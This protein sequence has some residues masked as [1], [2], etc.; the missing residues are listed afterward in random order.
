MPDIQSPPRLPLAE[1]LS[2]RDATTNFDTKLVNSLI[3]QTREGT[4]RAIKRNG[5]ALAYQGTVGTGQGITNYRNNLYAISGD[6][7]NSFTAGGSTAVVQEITPGATFSQRTGAMGAGLGGNLYIMGGFDGTNYLNDVWTSTNGVSWSQVTSSAP[8][9]KRSEGK[10]IVFNGILYIMGGF[11]GTSALG[12]VWSTPDGM[13]WTR[14]SAG[15]WPGR[16]RF[17]LT[18]YNNLMWVAGGAAG[19]ALVPP[20]VDPDLKYSDVYSSPDGIT[21]TRTVAQAPWVARNDFAFYTDST[22]NRLHVTGGALIDAYNNAVGDSWSTTDGI[23]W[24]RDSSNPFGVAAAPLWPVGAGQSAG[25]EE[26]IPA[27]V[28]AT[29]GGGTGQALFGFTDFDDDDGL[30]GDDITLGGYVMVSASNP[31]SGFTSAPTLT[32]GNNAGLTPIVYE[33]L[34]GAANNGQKSTKAAQVGNTTYIMEFSTNNGTFDAVLWS[35]VDGLTFTNVGLPGSGIWVSRNMTYFSTSGALWV[36]AGTDA[37]PNLYNDVWEITFS[38]SAVALNPNVANGFY[39]FNQTSLGIAT[40]LLVFKSTKDLYSYNGSTLTKLSNAANYPTTTVPGLVYLDG[41]FFVMDPQ[42]RIWNSA[43]NDPSTWTALGVIAMENEPNGGMGI[44]KLANYVVGFGVWTIEFFWDA[45]NAAPV[46]PLAPNTT[47]PVQVGC[48]NGESILEM[49]GSIVFVGQTKHE[50]SSVYWFGPAGSSYTPQK[51]SDPWVDRIL[52][53]D[54]LVNIRAFSQVIAGH[55]CYI[56]SLQQSNITLCYDFVMQSW[57]VW[58]TM[59]QN[60]TIAVTSITTDPFGTATFVAPGHGYLDGSPV[61]ITGVV[62]VPQYNQLFNITL[63]DAN[64]FTA[65]VGVQLATSSGGLSSNFSENA[66][67][68]IT[69]ATIFNVDYLQDPTNGQV[70]SSAP[71]NYTDNG[72][73]I[74]VRVVTMRYDAGTSRWKFYARISVL[75][76]IETSNL[77]LF[78][79]DDDYNNWSTSRILSLQQGQRA[80]T[81]QA[82]RSRRRAFQIYHTAPTP[83]RAEAL[84]FELVL[85]SF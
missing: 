39:H 78:Y 22:N 72:G 81:T 21:W 62:D 80:T 82:G 55:P 67:R 40:P 45:G 9:G 42:G 70:Y 64:T 26:T 18:I 23:N 61:N 11:N 3:E 31:G 66:Y 77:V 14:L 29:G 34:S 13:T 20:A 43:I 68:P 75:A 10:A 69:S 12:D 37:V 48:T 15:A 25:S 84:E 38:G 6:T 74:P 60:S 76:D 65:Q 2:S 5:I 32:F 27:S 79:S 33:F 73:P 54:P 63:V 71:T 57:T 56:L 46:S 53:N 49:E 16:T 47:L 30:G 44:A 7:F 36:I 19:A 51:I 28:T 52:Q 35:T 8:W 83:F 1:S 41:Y 4:L 24:T 17:G 58:S 85:G 50:G 59:T